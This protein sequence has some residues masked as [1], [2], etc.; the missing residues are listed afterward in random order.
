MLLYINISEIYRLPETKSWR[1]RNG[2]TSS[3]WN[4]CR[5]ERNWGFRIRRKRGR[6]GRRKCQVEG[7]QRKAKPAPR[8]PSRE[9]PLV[10]RRTRER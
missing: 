4:P 6:V 5:R 10:N 2:A 9:W 3:S 7:L 8:Q 1:N